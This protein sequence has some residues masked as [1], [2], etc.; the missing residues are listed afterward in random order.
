LAEIGALKDIMR[1]SMKYTAGGG[2]QNE[3]SR[4]FMKTDG[5]GNHHSIADVLARFDVVVDTLPVLEGIVSEAT[6]A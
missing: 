4:I 1:K 3:Y 5:S 2:G 6:V